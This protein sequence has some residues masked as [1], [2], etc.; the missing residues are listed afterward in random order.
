MTNVIGLDLSISSTG[1]WLPNQTGFT[2]SAPGPK[3]ATDQERLGFYYREFCKLIEEY[4]PV[5]LAVEDIYVAPRR[6]NGSLLLIQLHGVLSAAAAQCGKGVEIRKIAP[7]SLKK[8]ATDD[9]RASKD[10]MWGE[11]VLYGYTG[12][13]QDDIVDAWW[14][15]QWG[16]SLAEAA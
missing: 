1:V 14:L 5:L 8:W 16:V 2:L 4:R 9:G 12:P 7:T 15:H 10:E 3:K 11:A 13:H 6:L